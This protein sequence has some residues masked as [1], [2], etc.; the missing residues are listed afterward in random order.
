MMRTVLIVESDPN[1]RQSMARLFSSQPDFLLVGEAGTLADSVRLV[2]K[3]N[4]ELVLLDEKLPDS[5]GPDAAQ[6]ILFQAPQTDIVFLSK[7]NDD[8]SLYAAVRAGAKGYLLKGL[9][10]APFLAALRGLELGQAP[11]SRRMAARILDEFSRVSAAVSPTSFALDLLTGRELDVLR[12][13]SKGLTNREIAASLYI[14]EYTVKNHLHSI[15]E[16]L[17]ASNRREAVKIARKY[18]LFDNGQ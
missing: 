15:L 11:I 5:S 1:C 14:S 3:Y 16:K 12:E 13:L 17:G 9:P 6:A 4:P 8:E 7:K 18:G 10:P 2:A